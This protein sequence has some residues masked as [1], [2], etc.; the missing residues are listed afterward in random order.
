MEK[1]NTPHPYRLIFAQN[2]R[3]IRRL[4]EIS[5][6]ELALNAGI[7]KTYICEIENGSRAVSIDIMGKISDAL[8][9]PLEQLLI[10][11]LLQPQT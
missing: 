1:L 11:D 2:V 4:N 3:Q 10:R 7:S 8:N 9:M 5:Q 6:E